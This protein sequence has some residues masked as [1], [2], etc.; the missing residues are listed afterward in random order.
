M[1]LQS[2]IYPLLVCD[3]FSMSFV[4][5]YVLFDLFPHGQLCILPPPFSHSWYIVH[6]TI[7]VLPP[8]FLWTPSL[9]CMTTPHVSYH[10]HLYP[11]NYRKVV[12][13]IILCLS[14]LPIVQFLLHSVYM[15][16]RMSV[17][18][19]NTVIRVIFAI[20]HQYVR[21]QVSGDRSCFSARQG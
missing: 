11:D 10:L 20:Y 21:Y 15:F 5:Y 18:P 3:T 7:Y 16:C 4:P 2:S 8:F 17:L 6:F 13:L 9:L 12:P 19:P 14:D 1:I